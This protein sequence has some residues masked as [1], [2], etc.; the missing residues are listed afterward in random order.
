MMARK[1]GSQFF[2]IF[3]FFFFVFVRPN[4]V[5]QASSI[6]RGTA[7]CGLISIVYSCLIMIGTQKRY[8][9]PHI[10][11][12]KK[13]TSMKTTATSSTP[14][15]WN[16]SECSLLFDASSYKAH[17]ERDWEHY[18]SCHRCDLILVDA[19]ISVNNNSCP[20]SNPTH[21]IAPTQPEEWRIGWNRTVQRNKM[22]VQ[23]EIR[24]HHHH[25]H[26]S[27]VLDVVL[28]G[29][30]ITEHWLG[31]DLGVLEEAWTPHDHLYHELFRGGNHH[32]NKHHHDYQLNA[33]FRGLALGV[34]GDC[35]T[36]VL[37]R[38]MDRTNGDIHHLFMMT[39]N[40]TK[41]III[42]NSKTVWWILVGTND[43]DDLCD[44]WIITTSIIYLVRVI[45]RYR[46]NTIVVINSL[47]PHKIRKVRT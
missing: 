13:S 37:Q 26:L 4:E 6:I 11:P 42:D 32:P 41:G 35:V 21:P 39:R 40:G 22:L 25:H 20:C 17:L 7:C 28:I 44:P 23:N 45:K 15:P 30:S 14:F 9:V 29:D 24:K 2:I 5:C 16:Q 12:M 18:W 46:P 43:A 19:N 34:A 47:L 33:S 3:F 27:S 1:D 31:T 10:I 38:L 36:N 8:R